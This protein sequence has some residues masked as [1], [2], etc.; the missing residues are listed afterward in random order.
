MISHA[1]DGNG[2]PLVCL[3][4]W[5]GAASDYRAL[6]PLLERDSQVV[7]LHGVHHLEDVGP[8]VPLEAANEV[9]AA[10]RAFL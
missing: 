3:H 9:A 2:V 1:H 10:V 4:G 8:F 7:D 6:L 5:P